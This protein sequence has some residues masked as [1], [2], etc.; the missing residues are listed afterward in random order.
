VDLVLVLLA[1]FRGIQIGTV[2][3][4]MFKEGQAMKIEADAEGEPSPIPVLIYIKPGRMELPDTES[5]VALMRRAIKSGIQGGMRA[6]MES[7]NMLTGAK[8]IAIDFYPGAPAATEG[9]FLEYTTIPTIETGFAQLEQSV[10]SILKTIDG[11]PLAD[12]VASA[13]TALATLNQSLVGLQSIMENQ[14]TQQI[15]VQL[16]KTLQELRD[17]I[18]SLSPNSEAYRSLNSSLLSLNRTMGNLESLTRTLAEQ[19]NAVLISSDP[20]PDP[21]PEVSQQ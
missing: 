8:Y 9:S 15:P 21:I 2:E 20:E 16:D 13:N 18:S 14:S 19:P 17:A 11:L 10:N 4:V 3:R 7:G 12:T 6:S 1:E 5:S